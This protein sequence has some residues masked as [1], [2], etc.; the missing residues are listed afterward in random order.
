VAPRDQ[1]RTV[2]VTLCSLVVRIRTRCC[3]PA[4]FL[5]C[6]TVCLLS[7]ENHAEHRC[8]V[9]SGFSS[10][11]AADILSRWRSDRKKAERL[12]TA[13]PHSKDT[14][15]R[16]PGAA[17]RRATA[18]TVAGAE[19]AF[20]ADPR[21]QGR[22][23]AAVLHSHAAHAARGYASRF[24]FAI[25]AA[26]VAKGFDAACKDRWTSWRLSSCPPLFSPVLAVSRFFSECGLRRSDR[27]HSSLCL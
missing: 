21:L 20:E 12:I 11:P 10:G 9:T 7:L 26:K 22:M 5:C 25:G 8:R 1:R 17:V 3:L 19:Q 2:W 24:A 18:L 16:D 27:Q 14:G 4:W 6:V 23:V 13:F 15:A